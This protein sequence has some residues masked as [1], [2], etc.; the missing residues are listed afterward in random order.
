MGLVPLVLVMEPMSG[1]C[2]ASKGVLVVL[3]TPL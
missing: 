2:L 1:G 3:S